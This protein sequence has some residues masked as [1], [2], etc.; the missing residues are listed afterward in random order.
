MSPPRNPS[1]SRTAIDGYRYAQPFLRAIIS[2]ER[3]ITLNI[4]RMTPMLDKPEKTYELIDL[5]EAAVPFEVAL[6]PDLIEHLA[7]QQNPITIK[8]IE[9][10][11]KVSYLGDAGGIMCHI[12][13]K[14]AENALVISLSHVRVRTSLPFAAAV[15]D[16]QKHRIKKLKKK[17]GMRVPIATR[18][19]A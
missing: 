10:V 14:D 19:G 11:S 13:P 9:T 5:L 18:F 15:L 12:R 16:Y 2:N 3:I 4:K 8:S 7:R 17:T 6:M 1:S